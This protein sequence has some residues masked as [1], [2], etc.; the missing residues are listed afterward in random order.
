M[1]LEAQVNDKHYT[2]DFR[3]RKVGAIGIFHYIVAE[4]VATSKEE[5]IEKLYGGFE[6]IQIVNVKERDL[7]DTERNIQ[8]SVR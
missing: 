6:H 3:G 7:Y 2:I 1:A 5:A 8:E 4:I